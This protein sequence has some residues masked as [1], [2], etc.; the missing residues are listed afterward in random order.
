MKNVITVASHRRSGTHFFGEFIKLNWNV[1]WKKTH[2]MCDFDLLNNN[3][4]IYI[5]RNPIEVLHSTYIWF[6]ES[7]GCH[8][9][10]ITSIFKDVTFDEFL[11]GKAGSLI[12]YD[13]CFFK[14]KDNLYGCNGMFYDPIRYWVD[15]VNSYS[16]ATTFLY[17]DVLQQKEQCINHL[18]S[19]L[20]DANIKAVD[21]YVGH[22]PSH[23]ALKTSPKDINHFKAWSPNAI[24][25]LVNCIEKFSKNN[26]C[27]N[28]IKHL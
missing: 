15:H 1:E 3:H 26:A 22:Q 8:N 12:G 16:D 28:Y 24:Q 13:S 17:E 6:T 27:K 5:I 18:K 21:G 2:M 19:I 11:Q 9:K 25:M 7:G 4:V 23:I 20:G 14:D 10:L